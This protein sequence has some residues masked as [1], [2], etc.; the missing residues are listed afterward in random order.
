MGLLQISEELRLGLPQIMQ[1]YRLE[2]CWAF[3]CDNMKKG[4]NLHA[5]LAAINVNL[6]IGP[7]EG[8]LDPA[9]GGLVVWDQE[10]PPDW[11]FKDYNSNQPKILKFLRDSHATAVRVPYRCNR[12][13]IFNSTLFHETDK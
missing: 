7:D 2:Q 9:S 13:L 3:K 11:S 6:W 1:E 12:A 5:D 8:N 4:V 10:S